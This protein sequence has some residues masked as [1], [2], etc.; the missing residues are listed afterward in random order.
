M[1]IEKGPT[2]YDPI[3]FN[4]NTNYK[5]HYSCPDDYLQDLKCI[6][7][8]RKAKDEIVRLLAHQFIGELQKYYGIEEIIIGK[9]SIENFL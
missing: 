5:F 6:M 2:T 7:S 1:R 8:E 3:T 9:F 4:G